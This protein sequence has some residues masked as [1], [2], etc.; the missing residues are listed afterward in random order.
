MFPN[1]RVMIAALL[2]SIAGIGC[3][4]GALAAF[5]VNHQPFTRMESANP[6]LQLAF[7]T[8]LPEEVTDGRPAP[9]EVRFQV[10]SWPPAP[11]AIP[12]PPQ[13]VPPAT[14][15]AA[16]NPNGDQQARLDSEPQP[17]ETAHQDSDG[18]VT[19]GAALVPPPVSAAPVSTVDRTAPTEA[20]APDSNPAPAE[21]SPTGP[22][23]TGKAA[24]T[25]A[26]EPNPSSP[27]SLADKDEAVTPNPVP[28]TAAP[29]PKEPPRR[30]VKLH[31]KRKPQPAAAASAVNANFA[32]PIA[33]FQWQG[34][35][36][37]TPQ[38]A[39][40]A[41]QPLPHAVAKRHRSAKKAAARAA[42]N[43]ETASSDAPV[44]AA[45]R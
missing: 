43:G 3:G 38:T 18:S 1:I 5:R 15:S 35:A 21:A 33:Q 7:G 24:D 36:Q 4:L 39:G 41:P 2:A 22:V 31:R 6:P 27:T 13:A 10:M 23:A 32:S 9:F 28:V 26:V 8:G 19:P 42:S 29:E 25:A 16:T 14:S 20:T 30:I 45:R 17:A 40:Q 34:S 12:G 37:E 44:K 11:S